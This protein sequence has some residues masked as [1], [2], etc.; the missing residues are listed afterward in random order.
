MTQ[1][2]KHIGI[3]GVGIMGSGIAQIA[4]QSGHT[5][6]LYDTKE[7][8]ALQAKD[9]LAET[10]NKLVEKNKITPEQAQKAIDCLIVTESLPDL[11]VCDLIIEAI[12]ERLD[13][14]QALMQQL[15]E[16]VPDTTILASNTSSLSVTAIAAQCR[17]PERVIGYHFFN[18][19]PLMKV[20]EVIQGLKTDAKHV[21]TMTQLAH[22]F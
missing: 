16:I 22:A 20:V 2:I 4:A 6:Y 7:G 15:E 10:L 3:I 17:I 11:K 19:V 18:P 1:Q 8:A 9:K 13:I 14:K 12:I 5:T 21:E